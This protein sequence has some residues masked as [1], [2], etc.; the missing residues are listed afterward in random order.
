[1]WVRMKYGLKCS[2]Y[3]V[4]VNVEASE[5]HTR[6]SASSVISECVNLTRGFCG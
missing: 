6:K 1:M 4:G 3:E 2:V 5:S